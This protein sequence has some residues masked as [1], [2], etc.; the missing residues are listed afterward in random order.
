MVAELKVQGYSFSLSEHVVLGT[1]KRIDACLVPRVAMQARR[2]TTNVP[3]KWFGVVD[4]HGVF[5]RGRA[6][7]RSAN[8]DAAWLSPSQELCHGGGEVTDV[9]PSSPWLRGP[10][11]LLAQYTG[12]V[13]EGYKEGFPFLFIVTLQGPAR[14]VER[15]AA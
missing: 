6:I 11:R 13:P 12:A 9:S 4:L 7:G 5:Y 10:V 8:I 15:R 3:S 14:I 1:P 2:V